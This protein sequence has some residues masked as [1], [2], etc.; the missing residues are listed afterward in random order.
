MHA[1]PTLTRLS[2]TLLPAA[3]RS[4]GDSAGGHRYRLLV[5][6]PAILERP[7]GTVGPWRVRVTTDGTFLPRTPAAPMAVETRLRRLR[8]T[9][10]IVR[11]G[12]A[13]LEPR[14]LVR[15][16][17]QFRAALRG[18][19][20][21]VRRHEFYGWAL[22]YQLPGHR[23]LGMIDPQDDLPDL[24]ACFESPLELADRQEFLTRRGIPTRAIALVTQPQDFVAIDQ[25]PPANRF[26]PVARWRR[27]CRTTTFGQ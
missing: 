2:A 21:P 14:D 26:C 22:L 8:R 27:A 15:V 17:G 7:A 9:G 10:G 24:P 16:A 18:P 5:V 20:T 25:A 12:A 19:S 1:S 23:G 11:L 3:S 6:G 4:S 13:I